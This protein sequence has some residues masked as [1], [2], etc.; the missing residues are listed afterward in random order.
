[1]FCLLREMQGGGEVAEG[2][3]APLGLPPALGEFGFMVSLTMPT[4]DFSILGSVP[5]FVLGQGDRG[6]F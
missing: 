5:Y 1:M 3:S 6:L 2:Q 4:A